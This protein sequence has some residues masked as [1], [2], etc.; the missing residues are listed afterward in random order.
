MLLAMDTNGTAL[1]HLSRD[2]CIRLMASVP[3]G[4]IAYTRQALPAV[5]VVNFTVDCGDIVFRTD[6]GG[7][8]TAAISDAVVAFEADSMDFTRHAGWSVT[9]VGQCRAVT[10]DEEIR[11]LERSGLHPWAPGERKH[12]IKITPVIVHGRRLVTRRQE[13]SSDAH[14]L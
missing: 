7:K 8:L 6:A 4:R 11:R 1:E 2:E 3:V 9:V 13:A 5:E 10:G 14:R 12:F